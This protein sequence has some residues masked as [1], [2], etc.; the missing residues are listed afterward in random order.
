MKPMK[1]V[2][3]LLGYMIVLVGG[4]LSMAPTP[5][6]MK[7]VEYPGGSEKEGREGTSDIFAVD[8][9]IIQPVDPLT[10]QASGV[11]QHKALTVLKMIDKAT[12]GL[13]KALCTGQNLKEVILIFYR[14]DPASRAEVRY[15]TITLRNARIVGVKVM[16]PTSFDPAYESY[17][18]MEEVR[19]VYEEIEWN[20]LPD[21]IVEMDRWRSP[22]ALTSSAMEKAGVEEDAKAAKDSASVGSSQAKNASAQS[23]VEGAQAKRSAKEK[24]G[25]NK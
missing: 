4:V 6:N 10:G 7:I 25:I 24:P 8:H 11:R 3:A 18:H 20:W 17:R 14:I 2:V 15:Y 1:R 19:F 23:S 12:P 16:M 13:N 22:G 5:C 9:E 21:S